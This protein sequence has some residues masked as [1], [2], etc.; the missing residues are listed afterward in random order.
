MRRVVRMT[1]F[2]TPLLLVA[3]GFAQQPAGRAQPAGLIANIEQRATISLNGPWHYIVDPYDSGYYDYRH[4]PRTD[5]YFRN[6]AP[7]DKRDLVEYDFA[8]SDTLTV[9]GDWNSQKKELFY[10]E[11]TVWYE[12]SFTYRKPP[13]KRVFLAVGAANY[14]ARVYVNGN[15][16]C[17]HEGGFT[18]F[19]CEVTD[20]VK[21]GENFVVIYVN[22]QRRRDAVPTDMTDWW[23]YGG[24][25]RDVELVE[26]PATFLEDYFLQ[27]RKGSAS[28]IE[29]W[30]RMSEGSHPVTVRIPELKVEQ[31]VQTDATGAADIRIDAPGLERWSPEHPR[32][33]EV[34]LEASGEVVRDRIGF[35]TI[36]VRGRDILVN[37]A[38]VFLRGISMHEEAPLRS[39]RAWSEQDAT[40]L[41]GWVQELNGNFARLAHYPHNRNMARVADRAGVFLWSEIPVYWTIDWENPATLANAKRQ[42]GEM[43]RRDKNR[44]SVIL[45]SVG[46][47]T[48]LTPARLAFMTELVN[49]AHR[50]D[51]GRPVTAALETHYDDRNTKVIDD[52]L[53]K[54]LDVL[55]CNEYVGWY[56]RTPEDADAMTWKTV[57][58]KPLVMSEF[59]GDARAGLHGGTDERWTEEYQE[60]LYRHQFEMLK[61]IDFLRGMSPW[62]LTDFR[63]PRRVLPAVQ[64][65]YNRKGL[66]SDKG[67]KKKA[68]F[69]LKDFYRQRLAGQPA[70]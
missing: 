37:G 62:I 56:E 39:G 44:A 41:I 35:R 21:D 53:G 19:N 45:W 59:G 16:V 49:T 24:L 9:P 25:T 60:N 12:R 42:L 32:L 13:G 51:P 70:R 30:V 11:G 22:N 40:T 10:Y 69:A 46:N 26:V 3:G 17:E 48:P 50:L 58:D 68:F 1:V 61:K 27:L 54:E 65:N 14:L 52:P 55:G 33:Y 43:I 67:E 36:E 2:A 7:R 29:G 15:Q 4:Q 38:P 34:E 28:Q 57:Y 23:N 64:D 47:E 5:G 66:V 8:K 18:G 20:Q 6:A 63:S 31:R